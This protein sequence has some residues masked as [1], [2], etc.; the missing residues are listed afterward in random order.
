MVSGHACEDGWSGPSPERNCYM[1]AG[2]MVD[3]GYA[4]CDEG[5]KLI[6]MTSNKEFFYAI[7]VSS[8]AIVL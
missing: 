4:T 2:V 6:E 8:V 1:V 5:S 7:S 3:Q